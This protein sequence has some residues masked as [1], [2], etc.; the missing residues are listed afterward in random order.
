MRLIFLL[1]FAWTIQA[2]DCPGLCGD[3]VEY[4]DGHPDTKYKNNVQYVVIKIDEY[5]PKY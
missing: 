3:A 5:Q 2:K 4:L 1:C